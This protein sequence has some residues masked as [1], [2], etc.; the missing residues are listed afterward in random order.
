MP[1]CRPSTG[2]SSLVSTRTCLPIRRAATSR[3]PRRA[4][5]EPGG[6]AR[7]R[8]HAPGGGPDD[9]AVEGPLPPCGGRPR[10]PTARARRR[11]PQPSTALSACTTSA[12]TSSGCSRPHDTRTEPRPI[13]D[14]SCSSGVRFTRVVEAGWSRGSRPAGARWPAGRGALTRRT[15]DRPRDR[16][17]GRR[18][19]TRRSCA[20][21]AW[22]GRAGGGTRGPGSGRTDRRVRPEDP[23]RGGGRSRPAGAAAPRACAGRRPF[24]ASK[25]VALAPGARRRSPRSTTGAPPSRRPRRGWRRCGRRCPWSRSAGPGRRP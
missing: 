8:Y 7:F 13:P 19:P 2:P 21:G 10:P 25:G 12:M 3:R 17:R 16:P 18:R 6:Q 23:R 22:P 1:K 15:S 9:L 11:A 5:H 20:S 24:M 14:C 4:S